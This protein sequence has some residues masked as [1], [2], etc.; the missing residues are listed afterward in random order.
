MMTAIWPR[1]VCGLVGPALAPAT[2]VLAWSRWQAYRPTTQSISELTALG[3]PTRTLTTALGLVRDV[4]LGVFASGVTR[5]ASEDRA[6]QAAGR[7]ILANAAVDALATTFIPRDNAE[8][9]WSR[10]NT[11]NTLV[12]AT[13]VACSI[14]AMGAGAVARVGWFRVISAGIPV[15]YAGLT[16]LVLALPGRRTAEAAATGAQ[17]RTMA[18]AYQLWVAALAG[19]LMRRVLL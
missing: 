12:M 13:G 6:L 1:L 9:T 17:E 7:F 8:P 2:D 5:S 18:Y 11:A 16:L 14:G 15:S 4:S 10:R 3:A 19:V